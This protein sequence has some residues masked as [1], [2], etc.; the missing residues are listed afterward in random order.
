AGKQGFGDR[1]FYNS[2]ARDLGTEMRPEI[3][4]VA[5]R[6]GNAELSQSKLPTLAAL[7]LWTSFR[8]KPRLRQMRSAD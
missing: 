5:G 6:T 2:R 4:V 7:W 8:R 3:V 1:E